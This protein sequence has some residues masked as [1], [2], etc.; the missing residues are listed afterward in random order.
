MTILMRLTRI[1]LVLLGL[2]GLGFGV[3]L[4]WP[5]LLAVPQAGWS[6]PGWLIVGPFAHDGLIAPLVGVFGLLVVGRLPQAWRA[7]VTA[8]AAASG[9]LLLLSVPHLWRAFAPNHY[10]GLDDRDYPAG[11]LIA[12]A[13]VWAVA[14]AVG[15]VRALR[16]PVMRT[17]TNDDVRRVFDAMAGRYDRTMAISERLLLPG[18]RDWAVGQARGQVVEIAVGTGLNLPLYPADVT[19]VGVELSEEMLDLARRKVADHDLAERVELRLGDVQAL[20]LPDA[21]ADTVVSTF[22]MCTIPDPA[23]A[24]REAYRVL[25]P[26]GRFVLAEHGPS[27]CPVLGPLLRL[28][29]R[30]TVR[31]AADHLTRDPRPLLEEAGFD[32]ES[33]SRARQG[34][35]FRMLAV[36]PE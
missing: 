16:S 3:S 34:I 12:L 31:F 33:V 35:S 1:M 10:P 25:R 36:R 7:P 13:V 27:T 29:E 4:A 24:M 22:T 32:I 14:L 30:F 18:S 20:D 6:F 23:A 8:G 19:V 9:V 11:L 15:L 26:G 5:M 21:S 2:A 17:V 28:A